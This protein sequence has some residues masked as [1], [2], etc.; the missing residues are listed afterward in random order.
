MII[1][2]IVMLKN[3][4]IQKSALALIALLGVSVVAEA[5]PNIGT[6][7]GG[8]KQALLKTA[9][10]CDPAEARIDLDINNVRARLMTGGDMWWDIGASIA[11]YEV[12]KGT[13]KNALF[14]GSV[15]IGGYTTDKQ[16]KVAG[17]T[18]R[19]NGN[20]YWPGPLNRINNIPSIDAATCSAWDRFWKIDRV[21]VNKFREV[22][23]AGGGLNTAEFRPIMEWPARGNVNAIGNGGGNLT[24]EDREYAPF[25]D[26]NGNGIY[27]PN[28]EGESDYPDIFGDQF[29]WWVFNDRGNI[30]NMSQTEAIGIEVQASAFA[31]ATKDFLNDATFYNYRLINHGATQLDSTFISTWTDADLGWYKDDYIGCDT[32]RG[33]GI[34]YNGLPQDGQSAPDHYGNYV[35]MVGVDFFRGPQKY[36]DLGN[37]QFDTVLLNM[38]A[39]TYYDNN[40]DNRIGNPSNGIHM[41]NYM[42]GSSRNGQRFVNDFQGPG[43]EAKGLGS[44]PVTKFLFPGEP[45]NRETWSECSCQNPPDDRRF[46]H[47]AGP[48]SL[49]PG[50]VNDIT[51]GA[52]WVAD[53]G[54]CPNTSFRKIRAA[55]DQAQALFDNNFRTIEGPEAPR[56]V[57]REMNNRLLFYI[58][59]DPNSTNFQEKFGYQTDSVIYRVVSAKAR[60]ADH[61][62]S[63]YKFEG[64]RVFQLRDAAVQPAQIFGEDGTVNNEVAIEVFQ[65]DIQNGISQ[66][67]NWE[68]DISIN[69]C[70]SC[71]KPIVKVNGRD[72]GIRHSFVLENDA[73]GQG[74]NTKLV[75]Y[76]TY[77][78]VAIAYAHNNFAGFSPRFAEITQ[79]VAYLESGHGPGG[80]PI[81]VVAA[82]PN[83]VYGEVG[84]QLA[85]DYG[86]GVRIRRIE[87]TG[88][89]GNDLQLEEDVINNILTGTGSTEVTYTHGRGPVNIK[90]V[91]PVAIKPGNWELYIVNRDR[92][93]D[94][95]TYNDPE[96]YNDTVRGVAEANRIRPESAGWMLVKDNGEDVIYSETSLARFNEQILEEYGL[97]ITVGQVVRPGDDQVNGNGLITSDVTFQNSALPWL[98]GVVDQEGRSLQNWVRSGGN[99]DAPSQGGDDPPICDFSDTP[100]DTIGQ[101][102][103]DMMS[104]NTFTTGTWTAY[105]NG[106]TYNNNT[107]CGFGT[108]HPGTARPFYD[109]QSV[110]LVFTSD[111]TKWSRCVVLEANDERTLTEGNTPKFRLRG[112][113]SWNGDIDADGRP[114]YSTNTNDTGF[115]Y[116]PGYAINQETGERLNVIFFE[117]SYLAAHGG[118]DMIWNP[119]STILDGLGNP[120]FGGRHWV[121]ISDTK[122]DGCESLATIMQ[123]N[124]QLIRQNAY[125][126]LIWS[127]M[128]TV[129]PGFD[130]LPLRDGL[131]PTETKLRFRV[132]RP[133]ARLASGSTAKNNGFPVFA[134]STTDI[135]PRRLGEDG[136]TNSNQALLDKILVV[137]NPY[138]AM[139][140]YENNRLDTRVRITNLP[141][142]ATINIYQLDGTLVR[143]LSKDDPN[144]SW[145]DWDVRN[146][147]G[148]PIASGMYLIHVNAEGLGETVL[149]WFGA[150]RPVDVTSY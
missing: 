103:E 59:N 129:A 65:S 133:Y 11:Q 33:L 40:W 55:D 17:Q 100:Y 104:N 68:K 146:H 30:K 112:H 82:M 1:T 20:D 89:G 74:V 124:S 148:L 111:R 22:A 96:V 50:A 142:R 139:A 7:N 18:Y 81:P 79:D 127:G 37:G 75:N 121:M 122:Y 93:Y 72:S 24:L 130:L 105:S 78:F 45:N 136:N 99:S 42:T 131:I 67:V 61:P 5:R 63:V 43:V 97:A 120:I 95:I 117:D 135:V 84:T 19:Q 12:P 101:F 83:P 27:D 109:L 51:I 3:R 141:T 114:V 54:G 87:G 46:I 77:Y 90:V 119:S 86:D 106:S 8:N 35:P 145:I 91:D 147:K 88:N 134:F 49:R 39:F 108:V 14:A 38:E 107:A 113:A 2:S 71:Y 47:S 28:N 150:M 44:G 52:V 25:V 62:D 10:G 143:R 16:L 36:I 4:I 32:T 73:F 85:A 34:L 126:T 64:Y 13:R 98:A 149:R 115:S 60:Q 94:D 132:T 9:A 138:Y 29:I 15:W 58:V 110:D 41:Y 6:P 31:F 116:F 140:G 125:R 53:V 56:L 144:N 48:F 137:P 23:Q 69:G 57:V 80:S 123:S 76:R 26:V 92:K 66:I 21:T 70:D 118:R 102:Y 128:P